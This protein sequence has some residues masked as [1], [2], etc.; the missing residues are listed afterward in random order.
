MC[1]VTAGDRNPQGRAPS[2]TSIRDAA[3]RP[4]PVGL[5]R[6][7]RRQ[8]PL[9]SQ[10]RPAYG[11]HVNLL[12]QLVL[13]A[14]VWIEA[15]VRLNDVGHTGCE[16]RPCRCDAREVVE[17]MDVNQIVGADRAVRVR[18][19]DGASPYRP[20]TAHMLCTSWVARAYHRNPSMHSTSWWRQ[21][22][23]EQRRIDTMARQTLDQANEVPRAARCQRYTRDDMKNSHGSSSTQARSCRR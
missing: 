2:A 22:R 5:L 21:D 6:A 18:A 3:A 4:M 8:R 7:C 15:A 14:E 12:D 17:P 16:R 10:K 11:R 20:P 1:L 9:P 19:I 23:G 13:L